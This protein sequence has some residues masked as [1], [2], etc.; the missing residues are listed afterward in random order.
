MRFAKDTGAGLDPR[1]CSG[2]F[3]PT[4]GLC[5]GG[6]RSLLGDDTAAPEAAGDDDAAAV[7]AVVRA[8][9]GSTSTTGGSSGAVGV[10]DVDDDDDTARMP[11]RGF[12]GLCTILSGDATW[13]RTYRGRVDLGVHSHTGPYYVKRKH[14]PKTKRPVGRSKWQYKIPVITV[15]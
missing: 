4:R 11:T 6:R 8:G 7:E 2:L 9:S 14:P 12:R 1:G 13:F 15:S 5:S 10:D 3:L